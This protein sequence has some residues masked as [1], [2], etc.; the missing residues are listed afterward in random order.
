MESGF[1]M[2]IGLVLTSYAFPMFSRGLR[3]SRSI[4]FGYWF[5]VTF[6]QIVAFANL[7]LF[8]IP[9]AIYDSNGFHDVAKKLALTGELDPTYSYNFYFHLL[10][11][12]YRWFGPNHLLGEQISI[13]AFALSC[14]LLL[15]IMRLVGWDKYRVVCLLAFGALPSMLVFGSLTLRESYQLFFF[16]ITIYFGLKMYLKGGVNTFFIPMMLSSLAMSM[17]HPA[18]VLFAAFLLLLF[19]ASTSFQS[20]MQSKE[21]TRFYAVWLIVI[22]TVLACLIFLFEMHFKNLLPISRI[23]SA[24]LWDVI[25]TARANRI[26]MA[27]RTTYGI[28]F[29]HSSLLMGVV[30]MMKMYTHYQLGP[31]P[32]Q[33]RNVLDVFP[34]MESILRTILIYFSVK[35][36]LGS[37]GMQRQVLGLMLISYFAMTLMWALGTTN[38]G[39][40]MRHHMLTWW[41]LV[42]AGVPAMVPALVP[43]WSKLFLSR[44]ASS[45]E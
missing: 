37:N 40:A 6:H 5:V 20:F 18:L 13:L 30:S 28:H 35:H 1:L 43:I 4:L 11:S 10:A 34:A 41:I 36:W 25:S 3:Q 29:D 14:V 15:K 24:D 21:R 44:G 39:T 31:F 33:I 7:Y 27:G 26:N 42:L 38:Y 9:G 23:M 16:M 8:Y 2:A 17:F 32:W 45:S 12:I 22:P 19:L